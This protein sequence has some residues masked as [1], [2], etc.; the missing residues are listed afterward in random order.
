MILFLPHVLYVYT[1]AHIQEFIYN[2]YTGVYIQF[3]QLTLIKS[4]I[5]A[6]N[7]V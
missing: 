5:H 2:L 4:F 1:V 3:S 6:D 7:G